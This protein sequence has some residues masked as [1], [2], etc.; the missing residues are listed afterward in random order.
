MLKNIPDCI[1]PELLKA[2]HEMGHGDRIVIG[3]ANFPAASVAAAE[4]HTNI[5][6]DGLRATELLDAI[7]KLLPLD[8]F[9]EKPVLIMDKMPM[10]AELETPVWDAFREIVRENAPEM[11]DRIG[12]LDRFQFYEE[13]KQAYAVVSTT[14]KAFYAC[15]IL[16][17]GCL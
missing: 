8:D 15:I 4:H 14:E 2:L 6:C 12:F 3:D 5:R 9:V 1:S 11:A 17:K 16:Q 10:H 13:A 7:L